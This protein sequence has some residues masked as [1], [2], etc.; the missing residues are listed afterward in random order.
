MPTDLT[1]VKIAFTSLVAAFRG[2]A[3]KY[4]GMQKLPATVSGVRWAACMLPRP[5]PPVLH[6]LCN[7]DPPKRYEATCIGMLY[8]IGAVSG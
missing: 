4:S 6:G 3:C 2:S 8:R 1:D 5:H 7:V